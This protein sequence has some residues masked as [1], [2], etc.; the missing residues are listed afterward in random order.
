MANIIKSP[1]QCCYKHHWSREAKSILISDVGDFM[2]M[3]V[4]ICWWHVGGNHY[5]SY[6]SNFKKWSPTSQTYNLSPTQ[7]VINIRH[8]HQCYQ[9]RWQCIIES[10]L[11]VLNLVKI[12]CQ[13]RWWL[14]DGTNRKRNLRILRLF[15]LF[16]WWIIKRLAKIEMGLKL[17]KMTVIIWHRN[18]WIAK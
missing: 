8:Q 15:K 1:I 9:Y 12:Q 3:S 7:T 2:M 10:F 14:I 11:W 16:Q 5:V 18:K 17:N 6:P 4:S 13:L